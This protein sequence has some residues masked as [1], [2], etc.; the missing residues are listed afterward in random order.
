MTNDF[1]ERS[2]SIRKIYANED[3]TLDSRARSFN[4]FFH[5]PIERGSFFRS[6]S[7]DRMKEWNKVLVSSGDGDRVYKRSDR[8]AQFLQS[9]YEIS[10][11]ENVNAKVSKD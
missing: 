5:F 7:D 9:R 1:S 11:G 3:L 10:I 8:R 4:C 6:S 2:K